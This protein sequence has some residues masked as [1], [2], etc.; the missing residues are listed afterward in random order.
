MI[1]SRTTLEVEKEYRARGFSEFCGKQDMS[2]VV[3]AVVGVSKAGR[4]R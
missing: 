2:E 4:N 1:V 3:A